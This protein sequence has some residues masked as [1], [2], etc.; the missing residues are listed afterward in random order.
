MLWENLADPI[1]TGREE[2]GFA[3]IYAEMPPPVMIGGNYSA[4]ATWQGFRFFE[5]EATD[6]SETSALP[7][8]ERQ[9]PL[10]V[11]S[12][13]RFARR[14]GCR[15]SRVRAAQCNSRPATAACR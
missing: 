13:H 10:Q 1:M 3:K 9:L 14:S 2:L 5:I 12:A 4:V 6:L 15:L 11:H 8:A 7:G